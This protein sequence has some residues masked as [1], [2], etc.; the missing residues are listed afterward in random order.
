MRPAVADRGADASPIRRWPGPGRR[1]R[2]HWR[3]GRRQRR[4][5][6]AGPPA[7]PRPGWACRPD[8]RPIPLSVRLGRVRAVVGPAAASAGRISG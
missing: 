3:D 7:A 4:A 8:R 2:G 6:R 5:G 1:W